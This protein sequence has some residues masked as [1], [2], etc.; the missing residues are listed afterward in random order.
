MRSLRAAPL[1][2]VCLAAA[3]LGDVAG[4]GAADSRVTRLGTG[5]I[6]AIGDDF[7]AGVTDDALA[8]YGQSRSIPALFAAAAGRAEYTQPL[9]G[10]PGFAVG[11]DGGRLTLAA[12]APPRLGREPRGGPP[13]AADLSLPYDNLAVPGALTSEILVAR[14]AATSLLGNP[15]YDLVLRDRGTVLEQAAELDPGLVL[16]W[17]GPSDALAYV[18]AGGDPNLAPGL[19]TPA[20]T[21][22]NQVARL[23]DGLL[24]ETD[25]IVLFN[26]PDPTETPIVQGVPPV[27]VDPR[28][29]EPVTVT[30]FEPARDPDT[31]EILF[32]PLT[33][34]TLRVQR[35]VP[36]PLIGPDGP[37]P[38]S[39]RVTVEALA[40]LSDGIGIPTA[41]GGTGE[42]LPDRVVLNAAELTTVR[43]AIAG[44]DAAIERLAA[45]RGLPVV[46]V[47]GLVHRLATGGVLSD[48]VLLSA[49]YLTGQAFSLDGATFTPKGYGL[50]TNLLIAVVNARF[51]TAIDPV[52]TADLPG[53][54]LLS[55]P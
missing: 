13:L 38:P 55:I 49:D 42:P 5:P 32:D 33:G 39:D 43:G 37:L 47:R 53:I 44:Y 23:L 35:Q 6:V 52:R 12:T 9:V 22:E 30:V 54:P 28:T 4:P 41:F 15:F 11:D 16:L 3:C 25:R 18:A 26:V 21:F 20:A 2:A 31:G 10:D 51:G 34:D 46:D 29:G 36:V 45:E 19:P 8:A 50:V 1:L 27:V 24:A 48:G 40:F 14:S 17:L 7:L